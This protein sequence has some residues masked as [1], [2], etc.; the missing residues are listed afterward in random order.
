METVAGADDWLDQPLHG[1]KAIG[2]C[3]YVQRNEEQTAYL[4]RKGLLDATK[5]GRLWITT[6]RRLRDQ[7]RRSALPAQPTM[8]PANP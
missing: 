3:R 6:P 7:L 1:A 4:L 5:R 8:L 2:E